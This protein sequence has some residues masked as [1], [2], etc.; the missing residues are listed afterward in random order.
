MAQITLLTESG[1]VVADRS[2]ISCV[3]QKIVDFMSLSEFT[4]ETVTA[5]C[6]W[7]A[8]NYLPTKLTVLY[9]GEDGALTLTCPERITRLPL[10]DGRC[11]ITNLLVG[12]DYVISD[13]RGTCLRFS[14]KAGTPRTVFIEGTDNTRDIGGRLSQ[15]KTRMTRQQM[16]Y[17]G[18]R[19]CEIP[20]QGL[21][22][23]R[24]ELG[25]KTELDLTGGGETYTDEVSFIAREFHSIRWYQVIF[26][27]TEYYDVLRDTVRLF[28]HREN[29]PFYMHCSLGRDR[30]GTI[31]FILGG[32]CGESVEDLYREH[33]LS[34]FSLRGDGEHAGVS[35]HLANINALYQGFC[36]QDGDTLAQKIRCFLR[37]I[38]VTDTEMDQIVDILSYPV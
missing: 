17:R 33:L 26:S 36:E 20:L 23:M 7:S 35:A 28:A 14:T 32:L 4:P 15:D 2:E 5:A 18:A 29:Y 9:D 21:T 19:M 34:F 31:A 10:T 22:R 37:K 3:Y 16:V 13:S 11:E 1:D 30:T 38:G 12:Y 6:D 25:I 27:D 24:D 8:Q